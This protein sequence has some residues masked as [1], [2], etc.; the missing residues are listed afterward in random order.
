MKQGLRTSAPCLRRAV[1]CAV[2]AIFSA[3][4]ASLAAVSSSVAWA[5]SPDPVPAAGSCPTEVFTLT[6]PESPEGLRAELERL[7][8]L[9]GACD[10]RDDFHARLGALRLSDGQYQ[11]AASALEKALLL[12]PELAGAQLDYAQALARLGQ[13][14]VALDLVRQVAERP[15]IEPGLRA[16][17]DEESKRAAATA[18]TSARSDALAVRAER[19]AG[20]FA[21]EVAPRLAWNA[22]LQSSLGRESNL[23]SASHTRALLLYIP[24]APVLVPL[25]ENQVPQ[26]GVALRL[27]AGVQLGFDPGFGSFRLGALAQS[28]KAE[29]EGVPGQHFARLEISYR[30]PLGPGDIQWTVAQQGLRQGAIY[31]AKELA[32]TV[33]YAPTLR[34]GRCQ[35]NGALGRSDQRYAQAANMAGRYSFHRLEVRCTVAGEWRLGRTA[36]TDAPESAERPGGEKYRSD[37][38]LRYE[39]AL[40]FSGSAARTSGGPAG[41][42][43]LWA[44]KGESRDAMVASALLGPEPTRTER[45]D[46][47]IGLWWRVQRQW[48]IGVDLE[49]STQRSTNALLDIRNV[50]VYTGARWSLR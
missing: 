39:R 22:L 25:S 8:S 14:E 50:A 24:G 13:R 40:D 45:E 20:L 37:L 21:A 28:R 38:Y 41:L 44:R 1:A 30:H 3:A 5:Q 33:D 16:W 46:L 6:A 49:A 18:R 11:A 23:A 7:A 36:G 29:A 12:N 10:A 43:S 48:Q 2:L 15:D 19:P 17:L 31:D 42:L 26:A 35:G 32:M 47:G 9:A 4:G 34:L 27:L